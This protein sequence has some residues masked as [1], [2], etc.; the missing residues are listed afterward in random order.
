MDI[1]DVFLSTLIGFLAGLIIV[2]IFYIDSYVLH[3]PNGSLLLSE[4]I[5]S[6]LAII[7]T[8]KR[9]RNNDLGNSDKIALNLGNITFIVI[10]IPLFILR[11]FT[12]FYQQQ[13][14]EDEKITIFIIL[15]TI[16]IIFGRFLSYII[17]STMKNENDGSLF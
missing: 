7:Y 8:I 4:L 13:N 10:L 17:I 3:L 11:E 1:K 5:I 15:I 9:Y 2:S 14:I 6:I 12:G 16:G